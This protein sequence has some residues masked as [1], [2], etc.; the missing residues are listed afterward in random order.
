MSTCCRESLCSCDSYV[1]MNFRDARRYLF[2]GSISPGDTVTTTV[3]TQPVLEWN[4]V[5]WNNEPFANWPVFQ[6]NLALD[7]YS[8]DPG[9]TLTYPFDTYA[10]LLASQLRT[11][12]YPDILRTLSC[13]RGKME[14]T[15]PSKSH[16]TP[17]TIKAYCE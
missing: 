15:T 14:R 17:R 12:S 5:L 7:Y 3:P 13:S 16:L 6:T 9:S 11:E 1:H 10:W 2:S 4:D 8:L